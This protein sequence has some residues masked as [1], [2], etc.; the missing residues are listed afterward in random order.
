MSSRNMSKKLNE[1]SFIRYRG[2]YFEDLQS[3]KNLEIQK[4]YF[5]WMF[6]I[7]FRAPVYKSNEFEINGIANKHFTCLDLSFGSF[8]FQ[9]VI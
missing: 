9:K 1:C 7:Q 2:R 5:V 6:S 3:A 8:S 4:L